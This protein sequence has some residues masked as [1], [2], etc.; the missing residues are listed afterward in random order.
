MTQKTQKSTARKAASDAQNAASSVIFDNP[1]LKSGA[2][3]KAMETMMTQ[4][5][6]QFEK[7]TQ[8]ANE[9][10][11]EGYE[12]FIK[13]G[14]IFAKGFEDIFKTTME[15]AQEAAEKQSQFIKEAM[16]SKTLNEF[17]EVQNKIAQANFDD[18]MTGATKISELSVKVLTESSEPLNKQLSK[19]IKKASDSA[20]A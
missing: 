10:G 15:M 19:S 3:N 12:A 17:T 11:R 9:L 4:G 5:K 20:A 14:S 1:F 8:D 13:S 18:F 16:S 2:T 6:N 7:L